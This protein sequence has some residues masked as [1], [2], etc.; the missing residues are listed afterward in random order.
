MSSQEDMAALYE[1]HKHDETMWE[2]DET[3]APNATRKLATTVTVRIDPDDAALLRTIA[4]R[5]GKG[6]SEII[7][8]AVSVYLRPTVTVSADRP[9][10]SFYVGPAGPVPRPV[11]WENTHEGSYTGP[12]AHGA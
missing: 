10:A 5:Q 9:N 1:Q 8:A 6:F 7:R 11:H 4:Q 2:L 3:I 12:S